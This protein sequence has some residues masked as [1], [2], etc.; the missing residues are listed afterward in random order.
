N[1]IYSQQLASRLVSRQSA[2]LVRCLERGPVATVGCPGSN[3]RTRC[4]GNRGG[5]S[6]HEWH[7][8]SARGLHDEKRRERVHPIEP[9]AARHWVRR[10]G[11]PRTFAGAIPTVQDAYS[12]AY[13]RG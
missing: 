5:I 7:P 2:S 3:R 9:P 4:R 13:G 12:A 1:S 8:G 11:Y 10:S 6:S